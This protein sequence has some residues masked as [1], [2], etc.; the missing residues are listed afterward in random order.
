MRRIVL[1]LSIAAA[2]TGASSASGEFLPIQRHFGELTI[3]RVRAGVVHV[4]AGHNDGRIRVIVRLAEPPLAVRFARAKSA[5][6]ARHLNVSIASSRAYIAHLNAVQRRA[7]AAI[8]SAIPSAR[9]SR[10]FQVVLDGM[11]VNIPVR[12]LPKLVSLGFV[13]KV[14]PSLQYKQETNESPS[15]IHANAL[16]QRT[17]ALGDG[18]KIGV[19]DT[20]IDPSHPFLNPS[21]M[22]YPAG[23]P[24]GGRRWTTPKVIVA[25]AFPGPGS[26]RLGRVAVNPLDP[27]GTHVSGIA[28]GREGTNAPP[29]QDHPSVNGLRG[30][31]P[32]AWLGNYR[33]FT[34]PTAFGEVA[35]TPEIIAAFEA[36]VRDGMDVVNF[37]GGGPATDPANDALLET[38]TNTASAGVIPV[39]S[40]GNDRDE[41]GVG[42]AGSPGTAPAA[43]SV[44]AVTNNH[45]FTPVLTLVTP[46]LSG[47]PKAIPAQPG[48]PAIPRAWTTADQPLVDVGT[49]I[50]RDGTPVERHLCGATSNPNGTYNPLRPG[51]LAGQIALVSRGYCSFVSK[52]ARVKA[53]GGIG[54][55][56]VNNRPGTPSGIPVVM[57][58][59]SAMVS[60]L[61]GQR[62]RAALATTSGR[63]A[64][65]IDKE[66]R[67][68]QTDRGGIVTYFSSAGPTA[69]THQLKPDLSAPGGDILSSVSVQYDRSGYAVF[70]GTS[71][72]APHITGS[73]AL[74]VQLHPTWSPQ[75]I[76]SA[77]ME[78]AGPAWGNTART[79]EAPVT[80]EG[81]G[82]ANVDAAAD[83]LVFT[84]PASLSFGDLDVNRGDA[85]A[86]RLV[87][88]SDVGG[89]GGTWQVELHPQSASAGATL[90]LPG[91]IEIPPGGDAML[92]VVATASAGAPEGDDYGL[93]ILRNG[94]Q[95]RRI[96]YLFLVTRPAFEGVQAKP[97]KVWQ[98]GTTRT[99]VSRASRY[100]FPEWAFGPPAG[101]NVGPPMEEGGREKLY[102]TL[103]KKPLV[104][105]G[106]AVLGRTEGSIIDPWFLGSPD[107]NDVQGYAGTPVNVNAL[108]YDYRVDIGAAGAVFPRQQ[109]FYVA[110]DSGADPSTGKQYPGRYLLKMWRND[111]KPPSIKL[112]T[113]RVTSG[114][115]LLIARVKDP[116]SGVDPYSLVIGYRRVL[117]GAAAYDPG[118]GLVLFPLPSVAPTVK[119][120]ANEAILVASDNQ[121]AKNI[122][123]VGRNILPNTRFRAT[124][125]KG[126]RG[127]AVS[128]LV[129]APAE[130]VHPPRTRLAVVAG[131]TRPIA[132]VHFYDGKKSIANVKKGAGGVYVTDWTVKAPDTGKHTLRAVVV[133]RKGRRDTALRNTHVCK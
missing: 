99:G 104:N 128:W 51:S 105:L 21:G 64:I 100:R 18:V 44:A 92:P 93:I 125:I 124:S 20:G 40:S 59:P 61:D 112:V 103:V 77:L 74:L 130:C 54:M 79:Q 8:R 69:F 120:G 116:Q 98:T 132:S 102:S 14:Y 9:I 42:S 115:P 114:R 32:R 94:T 13:T 35:N 47:E 119:P 48:L 36:A 57:D 126:V 72:A 113:T 127:P 34:V 111:V 96:P 106:V 71:M 33:V 1:V 122:V 133:D 78:T 56:L 75:Q 23:F 3:P 86:S 7:A 29:S 30:V 81:A 38:V 87:I 2:L 41:F 46:T 65:Q 70:D 63:G 52:S 45:V 108:L 5:Y 28:A 11:T 10:R 110:V 129:P 82:L 107:H 19:V 89:G 62:I 131:S 88:V 6:G 22:S 97:L 26:G 123:T 39:I 49:L 67:Q 80:L 27:H 68:I 55:I 15:I 58:V 60:D 117:V 66:I 12:Q 83:P 109:R 4:P 95:T 17:G 25:R 91:S 84:D 16:A 31:A 37:S 43:I 53:A 50:G 118:S 24:K 73:A 90:E 85:R 76:K 121:E 101:Y